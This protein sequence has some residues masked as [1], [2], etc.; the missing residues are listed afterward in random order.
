MKEDEMDAQRDVDEI[1]DGIEEPAVDERAVQRIKNAE[2]AAR[3]R[4]ER[5]PG[6]R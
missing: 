6:E 5:K 2:K 1:F 3:K 4:N